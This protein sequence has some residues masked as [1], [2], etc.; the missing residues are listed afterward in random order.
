MLLRVLEVE[1]DIYD[2]SFSLR[3]MQSESSSNRLDYPA[4]RLALE[5]EHYMCQPLDVYSSAE[6]LAL[7]KENV[8]IFSLKLLSYL[9]SELYFLRTI[10]VE[11]SFLV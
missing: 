9:F 8:S 5:H 3:E 6:S 4:E 10:Y 1:S 2:M 11:D 7:S